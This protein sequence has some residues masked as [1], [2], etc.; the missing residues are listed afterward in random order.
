[1]LD[2]NDGLAICCVLSFSFLIY[3]MNIMIMTIS[4]IS[5]NNYEHEVRMYIKC[6][7][8]QLPYS[9]TSKKNFLTVISIR[10]SWRNSQPLIQRTQ[11][12]VH[13]TRTKVSVSTNVFSHVKKKIAHS[14]NFWTCFL[15]TSSSKER[16][17]ES[18]AAFLLKHSD[19]WGMTK[20]L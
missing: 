4:S 11:V 19:F 6:L 20:W 13:L 10:N 1:M 7:L 18:E 15:S 8:R 14:R 5:Q 17:L 3:K 12:P 9:K 16:H 2:L